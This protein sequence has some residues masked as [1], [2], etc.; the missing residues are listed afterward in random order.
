MNYSL[1]LRLDPSS[2]GLCPRPKELRRFWVWLMGTDTTYDPLWVWVHSHLMI[3]SVF[4]LS[5]S[6]LNAYSDQ[7]SAEYF[8]KILCIEQGFLSVKLSFLGFLRPSG[9]SPVIKE[10]TGST[11]LLPPSPIPANSPKA[12]SWDNCRAH[13]VCFLYF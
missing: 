8:Q 6:L 9:L 13:L 10:T 3:L 4:S 5:I 2:W 12:R 7:N 1:L 11:I